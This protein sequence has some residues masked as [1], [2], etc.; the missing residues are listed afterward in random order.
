[1]H[2]SQILFRVYGTLFRGNEHELEENPSRIETGPM[3]CGKEYEKSE[4]I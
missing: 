2:E 4:S 3:K 1:M